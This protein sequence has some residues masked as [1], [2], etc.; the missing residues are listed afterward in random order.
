MELINNINWTK[1]LSIGNE[2]IDE[3]HKKLVLIFNKLVELEYNSRTREDFA[4]LL[5]DMTDYGLSHFRKEEDYMRRMHYPKFDIH[6]AAHNDYI[7]KVAMYNVDLLERNYVQL[8]EI[9][10]FLRQWW[11]NHIQKE[12]R[13]YEKYRLTNLI[14]IEY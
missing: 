3:E 7:Y 8:S 12:D 1:E 11:T 13:E 14:E 9:I 6:L 4:K 5:S 10:L 2:V